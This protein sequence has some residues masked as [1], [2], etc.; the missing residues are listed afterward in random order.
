[1]A[2]TFISAAP[3]PLRHPGSL[4]AQRTSIKVSIP[5]IRHVVPRATLPL[6]IPAPQIDPSILQTSFR[7]TTKLLTTLLLG[8]LAAKRKLL[9]TQV[10]SSLSK[11]VYSIFLPSLLLTNVIRTLANPSPTLLLLPLAA[12]AQVIIGLALGFIGAKVMRLSRPERNVYAVCTGFGNSGALPLLFASALFDGTPAYSNTVSAISFYLLG[13]TALFWSLGYS[14][15]ASMSGKGKPVKG[16]ALIKRLLPPP[17]IGALTGLFI[18]LSPFRAAFTA[19][20]IFSAL[21]TLG[22][23]YSPAAVLIL[24][25]SLARKVEGGD[26]GLRLPRMALGICLTRFLVLPILAVFFVKSGGSLFA[27]PF[28]AF[29]ILLEAVMPPAQNSTLILNME[30][31]PDEAAGVARI[32]LAVYLV[33][34]IPI[35][36]GLTLFLAMSGL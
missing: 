24:A 6:P 13:W 14:L 34:V 10:L 11:T 5:Q 21:T 25:G 29:A 3:L 27:N 36:V 35:S 23:G 32:L 7:A 22:A 1:M 28:I 30:K 26:T 18:G 8:V 31:R 9:D 19:S 20:P 16:W 33:G 15:L 17:L 12:V 4:A 2:L